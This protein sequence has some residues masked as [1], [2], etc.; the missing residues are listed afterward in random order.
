MTSGEPGRREYIVELEGQNCTDAGAYGL[1]ER[2]Y[3]FSVR[4][5]DAW[6]LV[7]GYLLPEEAAAKIERAKVNTRKRIVRDVPLFADQIEEHFCTVEQYIANHNKARA[8]DLQRSHDVAQRS[9]DLRD[10]VKAHVSLE[11]FE[12]L[13]YD[14]SRYPGDGL[15]GSYFWRTQLEHIAEHGEPRIF[16]PN[17][18]ITQRLQLPWLTCGAEL[19]WRTAPG[20]P[21]KVSVQFVGCKTVMIHI[22]GVSFT[23]AHAK[24]FPYGN[25]WIAPSDFAEWSPSP[26]APRTER[27]LEQ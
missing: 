22:I 13:Q 12:R 16:V 7:P 8:E 1:L 21:T 9:T 27:I 10:Q 24:P 6:V 14:R 20:G 4:R 11:Q 25:T 18:P 3:V 26:A 23:D 5:G 17:L 2:L 19:I 15:Y